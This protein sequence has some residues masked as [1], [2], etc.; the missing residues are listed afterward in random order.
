MKV[1]TRDASALT[2]ADLDEFASMGGAFGIGAVSKAKDQWVL[3]T[4][5][6]EGNTLVG[7][8][9]GRAHV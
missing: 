1:V 9:I 4:T 7:L 5:A 6:R 3:A 2:D 8:K